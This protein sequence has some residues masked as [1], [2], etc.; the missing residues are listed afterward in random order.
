MR[1]YIA[2][3]LLSAAMLVAGTA[4]NP[5]VSAQAKKDKEKVGATAGGHI[6]V[7]KGKDGKYRFS[8]RDADGK[9][10]AGS[11]AYATEK[12][13]HDAIETFRKVVAG[14]KVTKKDGEKP[15]K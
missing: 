7:G 9:Y 6:E 4:T 2:V 15:A 11:G 8:V 3:V 5:T 12:E 1:K 10:L 13:I 14:A